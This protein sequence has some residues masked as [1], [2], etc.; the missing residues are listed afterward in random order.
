MADIWTLSEDDLDALA[1]GAAI[2]GTGGGGNPYIGKLRAKQ[3]LRQGYQMKVMPFEGLREHD[4]VISVG[5]IGAPIVGIEKF[6]RG[7]ECYRAVRAVEHFV[8][9]RA[10]ALVASEIGGS[11]A[12]EPLIA[13]AYAGVPVVDA[14]GM[15]R[16]FPEIQMCTY[17]IYGLRGTPAALADEKG[18]IVV[19][20]DTHD[21]YWLE[22]LARTGA[23]DMGAT[24]GFA[25][26][27]MTGS[28]VMATAIPGTLSLALRLGRSVQSAKRSRIS[29]VEQVLEVTGANRLFEGKIVDVS[30]RIV[31]GFARGS[32]TIEGVSAFAD[33]Q[34]V[35]NIQNENLIA[36]KDGQ[37]V[38]TV[39]D[40]II[41]LD[42]DT[43]E[44]I[45]TEVLRYGFHVTVIGLLAP[46]QLCTPVALQVVGPRAFGYDVQYQPLASGGWYE[47]H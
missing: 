28:E 5:G 35:I 23:V 44:A 27:P 11:N 37:V 21:A 9:T 8:K 22:K 2:L 25:M 40:L 32:V 24:A 17:L 41:I 13:A 20:S 39:P 18:N 15:G 43:G 31:K 47:A 19:I 34:L 29:P 7:D 42:S 10:T 12:I 38:A 1:I 33:S 6:E 36:Y 26:A 14:D 4:V 45:T 16:A 30:R 46:R 3:V